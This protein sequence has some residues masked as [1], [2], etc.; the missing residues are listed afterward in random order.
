MLLIHLVSKIYLWKYSILYTINNIYII[1]LLVDFT[2][3]IIFFAI[4]YSYK[5]KA[6]ASRLHGE[7][8]H[9]MAV[10]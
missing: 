10:M 5:Y 2:E 1:W 6:T 3:L 9:E 8:E 7:Q 4:N